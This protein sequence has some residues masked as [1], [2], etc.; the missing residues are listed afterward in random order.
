MRR[1]VRVIS[2]EI[3]IN[4]SFDPW[5]QG[6][7]IQRVIVGRASEQALS[8][9]HQ[10]LF[11]LISSF[12]HGGFFYRNADILCYHATLPSNPLLLALLS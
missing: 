11:E 6:L 9:L 3:L 2:Q 1:S 12:A 8:T 10:Q 5:Y 7:R 4:D